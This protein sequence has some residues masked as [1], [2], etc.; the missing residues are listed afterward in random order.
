[1]KI[2]LIL[3]LQITF[4]SGLFAESKLEKI[5]E[6]VSSDFAVKKIEKTI[7]N[8]Y[9]AYIEGGEILYVDIKNKLAVYGV[10]LQSE[11][12]KLVNLT[13]KHKAKWQTSIDKNTIKNIDLKE[14]KKI[15]V[16]DKINGGGSKNQIVVFDSLTCP[17]CVKTNKFFKNDGYKLDIYRIYN[18]TGPIED[19]LKNKFKVK[20]V[21]KR[22]DDMDMIYQKYKIRSTPNIMVIRNNKVIKI[23]KGAN[24]KEIKQWV[25]KT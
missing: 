4:Y 1:M 3:L 25:N 18:Q 9:I 24:M 12:K 6:I 22:L 5:Q 23:I 20:N 21:E 7:G 13:K 14:I 8:F 19:L 11:D 15:A 17:Y 2:L 10:L 16:L